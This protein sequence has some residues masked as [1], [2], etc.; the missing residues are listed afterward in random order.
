[1]K[2]H[3]DIPLRYVIAV[4]LFILLVVMLWLV[5]SVLEPIIIAAFVAYLVN[6]I[7]TFLSTRMRAKRI[8]M[9][10]IVY[11]LSLA[12]LIAIPVTLTPIFFDEFK[13]VISDF[14]DL[15][16]QLTV[17][18][19]KPNLIP[20]VPFDFTS[21][22]DQM[23]RFKSTFLTSIPDQA[24]Q[25]IQKT[26]M[27]AL[28]FLV[29]LVAGYYFLTE[30]PRMRDNFIQSFPDSFQPEIAELYKRVRTVWMNYLRGQI[31]LMMIVGV[32]FTIAWTIIGIPGA[33]VLGVIAGSLT[34]I[35]DVGP[36][37]AA[38][39]AA[40]VA[41]LE[42]SNWIQLSNFWVTLIV[43]VVYAV[44][45]L[46]KNFWLRPFIMGRS[47]H[48]HEA[49]VLISIILATVLWGILGALLVVPVLASLAIIFDYLR[50]R[51]L[52]LPPFPMQEKFV[53]TEIPT[54]V[55]LRLPVPR[56]TEK[57]AKK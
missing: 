56:K 26:S 28:W 55:K 43:I 7:V 6:P 50:R 25:L 39:L 23:T 13:Q 22:T 8:L 52:G 16:D 19:A 47:V 10:N 20:G 54:G 9:A 1:M 24:L 40:A 4:V 29:I 57:K 11:F 5:R 38:M 35:P 18:L 34:L 37:L 14:L 48:M 41:L 33:L 17:W 32:V 49:L 51:I 2:T 53:A 44:L 31:L 12:I 46:I 42:G 30:W 45:I 27:G 36:F 21:L 15:F 3:W